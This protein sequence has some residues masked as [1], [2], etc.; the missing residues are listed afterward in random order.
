LRRADGPALALYADACDRSPA[1]VDATPDLGGLSEWRDR[2]GRRW[3]L[4]AILVH[5]I[6][7]TARPNGHAGVV[8]E[9]VDGE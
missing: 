9:A 8:R 6:E 3:S 5:L 1:V 7:E 2:H 4:R